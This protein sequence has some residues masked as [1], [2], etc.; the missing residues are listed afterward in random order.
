MKFR[1]PPKLLLWGS[2]S[3]ALFTHNSI[4]VTC[5]STASWKSLDKQSKQRLY[6]PLHLSTLDKNED[7]Q[8]KRVVIVGGGVG[9]LAVA[10]RVASSL[11]RNKVQS[12]TSTPGVMKEPSWEVIVLEKNS[13]ELT[14]GRCGSFDVTV[15][16]LGVFRHERGPSLLLLKNEYEQLFQSCLE[17]DPYKTASSPSIVSE[18]YGLK[19]EQCIP[20]YQVVFEDGDVIDLGFPSKIQSF[21]DVEYEELR[22]LEQKSREKMNELEADGASKWDAYMKATS[23]FLDCGL[24]NFIEERIDLISFPAFLREALKDGGKVSFR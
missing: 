9:G 3:I 16:G 6:T 17:K 2:M 18:Q 10:A 19:M 21:D 12:L 15:P 22:I 14:G 24:P 23:A 5:F 1:A 13:K 7:E 4:S 8:T 20:A 11:Q